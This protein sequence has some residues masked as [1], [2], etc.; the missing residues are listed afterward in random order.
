MKIS[1]Q[2]IN[3][4]YLTKVLTAISIL[5]GV[6]NYTTLAQVGSSSEYD[7]PGYPVVEVYYPFEG[8]SVDYSLNG[9]DLTIVNAMSVAGKHGNN[10]GAYS[11]SGANSYM[12]DGGGYNWL[13]NGEFGVSMWVNT[14]SITD[15]SVLFMQLVPSNDIWFGIKNDRFTFSKTDGGSTTYIWVS[16]ITIAPNQ[17]YMLSANYIVGAPDTVELYVNG[18]KSTFTEEFPMDYV[19]PNIALQHFIGAENSSGANGFIGMIDDV[20]IFSN[21]VDSALM[22]DMYNYEASS[23]R[24]VSFVVDMNYQI[25]MGNFDTTANSLDI[26]GDINSWLGSPLNH[27]GGGFYSSS[28]PDTLNVGSYFEFKF[29]H[30]SD[31]NPPNELTDVGNR[32]WTVQ[33]LK[34]KL[35]YVFNDEDYY[36]NLALTNVNSPATISSGSAEQVQVTI[37]NAG[38][39]TATTFI[40]EYIFD[41][42]VEVADTVINAFDFGQEYVHTFGS[43][44]DVSAPG[45]HTLEIHLASA[46]EN[47]YDDTIHYNINNLQTVAGLPYVQDFELA[48]NGWYSGGNNSSW[49]RGMPTK[50]VINTVVSGSNAMVTSLTS[51]VFPNEHSYLI[52]PIFQGPFTNVA[53]EFS[54]MIQTSYYSGAA[55]QYSTDNG[56]T[57]MRLAEIGSVYNGYNAEV[58]RLDWTGDIAGFNGFYTS[59]Q[60]VQFPLG[61][62][63]GASDVIFRMAFGTE[64]VLDSPL[65]GFAFDDFKLY[66]KLNEDLSVRHAF[67][68]NNSDTTGNEWIGVTVA[69]EGG[70]D[71]YNW[72]IEAHLD[73]GEVF[74]TGLI[75]YNPVYLESEMDFGFGINIANLPDGPYNVTVI[76]TS[77]IDEN[78]SND[79]L[80]ISGVKQSKI[81]TFPFFDDFES[82]VWWSIHNDDKDE[83]LIISIGTPAGD[84]ISGALSGSNALTT[85]AIGEGGFRS[86][87]MATSPWF[88]FSTLLRPSIEFIARVDLM[89]A[90]QA[91]GFQYRTRVGEWKQ[92]GY[93]DTDFWYDSYLDEGYSIYYRNQYDGWANA[94]NAVWDTV[95]NS[96]DELIGLQDVQ[97]RLVYSSGDN[98]E[99]SDGFAIDDFK[100]F[101]NPLGL[102]L[103]LVDITS[104]MSGVS[105]QSNDTIKVLIRN[106]GLTD[107][108]NFVVEAM[109]DALTISDTLNTTITSGQVYEHVFSQTMDFSA[110][111]QYY[112][113]VSVIVMGDENSMNDML[114]KEVFIQP[115]ISSLP[116][117]ED[118]EAGD[119]NWITGT[120]GGS[121]IST[122]EHGI[123][124]DTVIKYASSGV[125]VFTTG[126]M[127]PYYENEL[128][129]AQSPYFDLT[130]LAAPVV[131]LDVWSQTAD[132]DDGAALQYSINSG[133]DWI[134]IGNS[135][136][137][138]GW[139]N[140]SSNPA[141]GG[142]SRIGENDY[143][144]GEMYGWQAASHTVP[145][146]A[147]QSEV[148]FRIVFGSDMGDFTY[149]GFA[150][151]NFAIEEIPNAFTE[152]FNDNTLTDWGA[153]STFYYLEETNSELKIT[154]NKYDW[155]AFSLFKN[156]TL[157]DYPYL[158]VRIKSDSALTMRFI[159][160][161]GNVWADR[162]NPTFNV[163][164]DGLYH[165]YYYDFTDRFL[166]YQS[167]P[168][169]PNNIKEVAI[170]INAGNSFAG[171]VYIDDLKLGADA[172]ISSNLD[173]VWTNMTDACTSGSGLPLS[174]DITNNATTP[175][176]N[177]DVNFLVDGNLIAT[178]TYIDTIYPG[179]T[180]THNFA[181]TA[182]FTTDQYVQSFA[183]EINIFPAGDENAADNRVLFNHQVYGDYVDLAGWTSY[184]TCDGLADNNIW[185]IDE[186][187]YGNIW[188]SGFYGVTMFDG[189]NFTQYHEADGLISDYS[190]TLE[191]ASDGSVWFP[192]ANMGGITQYKDGIFTQHYPF[193]SLKFV[194]C[195]FEDDAGNMWFGSYDNT[196]VAKFD[197]TTW[198]QFPT[199]FGGI[200]EDIDQAPN[201]DLLF[202][203]QGSVMRWDGSSATEFIFDTIA[204][205]INEIFR[206]SYNNTW[207]YGSGKLYS[208]DGA[209]FTDYSTQVDTLGWVQAIEEDAN[210]NIWFGGGS[211]VVKFDGAAWEVIGS[212]DG[213]IASQ[214]W[215]IVGGSNGEV[216][217]GTR[218]GVSLFYQVPNIDIAHFFQSIPNYQCADSMSNIT[219]S[220]ANVGAQT[221]SDPELGFSVNGGTIISETY[222]GDLL[223]GDTVE[224]TFATTANL[225]T[226]NYSEAFMLTTHAFVNGDMIPGNDTISRNITIYGDVEDK[227]GWESYNTC[228]GVVDPNIWSIVQDNNND[229]WFTTFRGVQK[230]D[231]TNLYTYTE[232]DGLISDYSWTSVSASDGSVWFPATTGGFTQHKNG[233]FTQHFP[234][235]TL[236]FEECSF[237]DKSGNL[238]FGSY[239]NNGVAMYNGTTWTQYPTEAS[240]VVVAIGQLPSGDILLGN[241]EKTFKYDGSTFS[242]YMINGVT[243]SSTEIFGDSKKRT[244]F[245]G[246]ANEAWMIDSVGVWKDYTANLS[247]VGRIEA[248]GEDAFGTIWFGGATGVMSFDGTTWKTY[249]AISGLVPGPIYSILG[250]TDGSV[251]FGSYK[252]GLSV[253]LNRVVA[254]FDYIVVDQTASFYNKS[255]ANSAVFNWSFGDGAQS[256]EANPIHT[257]TKPGFYDVCLIVFDEVSGQSEEFCAELAVG[258]TSI[259]CKAEFVFEIIQDSVSFTNISQTIFTNYSWNFGDGM[260]STDENPSHVYTEGGY[261][262]ISF[263][264][265]D[266]LTYCYDEVYAEI[267]IE[268]GDEVS[269]LAD[270]SALVDGGNVKFINKSLGTYTD[271]LWSFGDGNYMSA[272][273]NDTVT[274]TYTESDYYEV[275]LMVYDSVSGCLDEYCSEVL[276]TIDDQAVC[277]ADFTY[278]I[279]GV[280]VTFTSSA[281]GDITD[282]MWNLGDGGF[283]FEENPVYTFTNPGFYTVEFTIYDSVSSCLDTKSK[284]VVITEVDA[285]FCKA[286]FEVYIDENNVIFSNTSLGNY[287]DVFWDFDD[288]TYSTQDDSVHMYTTPDYYEV[289]LTIYDSESECIDE[290]TKVIMVESEG[291]PLC[292]AQFSYFGSENVLAFSNESTGEIT[293]YF[294]DFGD[295]YYSFDENPEHTYN[296]SGYFEVY[297]TTYDSISD[298][299]DE[300][301]EVVFVYNPE[302]AA[303]NALFTFYPQEYTIAFTSEA[304]GDFEQHFWDFNDGTNSN[305][306]NPV[307][308]FGAPGY[309]EV[310]YTVIDTSNGCFDTR[311][312]VVFV[313]GESGTG[314]STEIKTLYSY[315]PES[316]SNEVVF[317]DESLGS[318]NSWYWDFGDNSMANIEQNPVYTY[319]TNDYYRVCLTASNDVSQ[320][321]KC[322]FIAVGDVT[323]SSTSFFTYFADS[324]TSTGHFKNK[325]LGNIVS[326]YWDFG[327]GYTS[328]HKNPSHTYADTGYYAACLTTTS[329]SGVQKTYCD[330]VRIGNALDNPCLFSC[331]WPGDANNDLEANHYDIMIIGLNYNLNGPKRENASSSWYGQFAQNWSTLQVD[332]TNNK[333]GDANGDG[334]INF[335]DVAS[336]EQNF[337]FSHFEQPDVKNPQ[338]IMSCV[339]VKDSSKRAGSRSKAKA[340]LSPPRKSKAGEIYGI[341]FEIEV[342][343]GEKIK[344]DSVE[345]NFDDSWIG[346]DG[347]NMLTVAEMDTNQ[348]IIYVGMARTDKKDVTGSGD[349]AEISFKFK[350]DVDESGVSFHATTQGGIISTGEGVIVDGSIELVLSSPVNICEGESVIIDL[351]TGFDTYTWSTGATDTSRIEIFEAGFYYVT[352]TDS[353]GA[354]ASDTVEVIVHDNPV[355]DLGADVTNDGSVDLDAGSGFETYL[356]STDSETQTISVTQSGDYWVKVSNEAGCFGYDTVNVT[357][358]DIIDDISQN[359]TIFPNP[360]NGKFWLV[361]EFNSTANLIVEIISV[362]G[363]MVW[364]N[365]FEDLKG[366]KN[367]IEADNLEKGV[368]YIKVID[369]NEV[370]TLRFI[371]D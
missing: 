292:D 243:K 254:D 95:R 101:D 328:E 320:E 299:L 31:W 364:R 335:D 277:S 360:N 76:A 141:E 192:A 255:Y 281:Q 117:F 225:F 351:G 287:T 172:I 178:E 115:L 167:E 213:L 136:S 39:N 49:E 235:D 201:G 127:N 3:W 109:G 121:T 74:T 106:M 228:D 169:D 10:P 249:N 179:D 29:R 221:I 229:V 146:L 139:Y 244:W 211:G 144:T 329:A 104:P 16:D 347:V 181:A 205:Y 153:D 65:D 222:Y 87:A 311:Y 175:I 69:N 284:V 110:I 283:A 189:I 208:Y 356:W 147:G 184:N 168:V 128:S 339:W 363:K 323:N 293:D 333:Y 94:Q 212:G 288:G 193:D 260:F 230:F 138:E 66:E 57:W 111:G 343:G 124:N 80:V 85:C 231:G 70:L 194:E 346:E 51:P 150:F 83:E 48:D 262:T 332:G 88:D 19:S 200:I 272:T 151:D 309:Y 161:D 40:V 143:W 250:N 246:G 119:G 148:V 306:E 210:G 355:V 166:N 98:M 103:A 163:I 278:F 72:S 159:Y 165:T 352:V 23:M 118:F 56:N 135:N 155:E 358:T 223:S 252:Q 173:I 13:T 336:I 22:I 334:A 75:D 152:D 294:W 30:N 241:Y 156:I 67:L 317:N 247:I 191:A 224:F 256:Q 289:S 63:M 1:T 140:H 92:L 37:K 8:D 42:G 357:V 120:M 297:L 270:F 187:I 158:S 73:N 27:D 353:L 17:W 100:I 21:R 202:A 171:V 4:S 239:S 180:A 275:C 46:D 245:F 248:I 307:H 236:L 78:T 354:T 345:V 142:L 369:D 237:E 91:M 122:W 182:D 134:T 105:K 64:G 274:Y 290:F 45:V 271:L 263:S 149:D 2:K 301:F 188:M 226:P 11:F 15:T 33:D 362:E 282:Y 52:S 265:Y 242:E 330:D 215:S 298:C 125:N 62:L 286:E 305:Q 232:A 251:W 185:A 79:T 276:I 190:W 132:Y 340:Q 41:G 160:T 279:D 338:W 102:D 145:E 240:G 267:L 129:Y 291:T 58:W 313:E 206:D 233:T 38:Y 217:F 28:I 302:V 82:T 349:I 257:Y 341:A 337:A 116:Y 366:H 214:V 266:S 312:K 20:K 89:S 253:F 34:N 162:Y 112:L 285:P 324:M 114:Y 18:V 154:A 258:D 219:I 60:R 36:D 53:V 77:Q 81:T 59:W 220:F 26:A 32:V 176:G 234:F 295:G 14:P 43:T 24:E 359:M 123:P 55:I 157:T 130:S 314:S 310:A 131:K 361:Y 342:I 54:Y 303:C 44:I 350:D 367:L 203:N 280:T 126:L 259:L 5:V 107:I 47:A 137:G 199:E 204:L 177:F 183:V 90:G 174:V 93:Y 113:N 316:T 327:D 326:Y 86:T 6:L 331:V 35:S 264:G 97:I 12:I 108:T 322:D 308:V 25:G 61:N 96:F 304:T 84:S 261:Y 186:D 296:E 195:S 365:E 318:I 325:S 68:D 300:N 7:L 227:L 319:D 315:I 348:Y 207:F 9:N 164:P 209:N 133:A 268:K 50:S 371:V 99:R 170:Q 196:G 344:W 71:I 216:G 198:T 321:T 218:N 273:T 238:W 269:C 197:G 368:Y 370:G